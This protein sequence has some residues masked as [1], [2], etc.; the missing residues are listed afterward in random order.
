MTDRALKRMFH[1]AKEAGFVYDLDTA[2]CSSEC[3]HCPA[4]QACEQMSGAATLGEAANFPLF[5]E[6]Y[7][8]LFNVPTEGVI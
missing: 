1:K 3:D 4:N 6:N 5:K 2:E 7:S 8:K